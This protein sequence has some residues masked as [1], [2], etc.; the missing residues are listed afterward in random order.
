M[1]EWKTV[2]WTENLFCFFKNDKS[3]FT[4]MLEFPKNLLKKYLLE[5][6]ECVYIY[7]FLKIDETKKKNNTEI[8]VY[9]YI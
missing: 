5:M 2:A 1:F 9:I 6:D 3:I 4:K 7:N 8:E